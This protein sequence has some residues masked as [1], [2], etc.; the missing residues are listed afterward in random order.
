MSLNSADKILIPV[1]GLAPAWVQYLEHINVA[2]ATVIAIMTLIYTAIK[3]MN[4]AYDW[5]SKWASRITEERKVFGIG[6][7][8]K[9]ERD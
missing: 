8:R 9:D 5:R 4:A 2:L 1:A 7:K 6:R 3:L